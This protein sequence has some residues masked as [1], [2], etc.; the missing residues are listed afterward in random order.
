M[1]T[2]GSRKLEIKIVDGVRPENCKG[3]SAPGIVLPAAAPFTRTPFLP[4][5][6]K[7]NCTLCPSLFRPPHYRLLLRYWQQE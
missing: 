3:T 7:A 1:P 5:T 2:P 6:L 4:A